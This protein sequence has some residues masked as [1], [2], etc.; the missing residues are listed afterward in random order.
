MSGPRILRLKVILERIVF[1]MLKPLKHSFHVEL[2]EYQ[3]CSVVNLGRGFHAM[4]H[5]NMFQSKE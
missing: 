5:L 1:I 3:V 4:I 2:M